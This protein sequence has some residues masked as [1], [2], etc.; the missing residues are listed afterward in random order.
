MSCSK[1]HPGLLGRLAQVANSKHS[2]AN[3]IKDKRIRMPKKSF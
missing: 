1:K 3:V 2:L